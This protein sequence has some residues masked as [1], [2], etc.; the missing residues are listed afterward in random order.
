MFVP[1]TPAGFA[2]RNAIMR[3]IPRAWLGRYLS[4]AIRTEIALA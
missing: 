2:V 1:A 3:A 4:S